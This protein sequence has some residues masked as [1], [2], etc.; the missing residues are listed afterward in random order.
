ME[1]VEH[2]LN[3]RDD[4]KYI[5]AIEYDYKNNIIYKIKHDPVAGKIIEQDLSFQ[6]FCWMRN[7]HDFVDIFYHYQSD[8]AHITRQEIK[9]R[10]EAA[11]KK[12][13]ITIEPLAD[14]GHPRLINGFKYIV[15]SSKGLNHLSEFFN[16]G[17]VNFHDKNN[18]LML[19][20]LEQYLLQKGKRLFKGMEDYN[21]VHRMTFDLETQDLTPEID[22]IYA[23]GVYDNRGYKKLLKAPTKDPT[24]QEEIDLIMDLFALID[25]IRPAVIITYNGAD[26]DWHF[27]QVRCD[28]LGIDFF[29]IVQ[30][31][32][33]VNKVTVKKSGVKIGSEIE[34]FQQY[35]LW[36]YHN[37]DTL[38][39]T[40]RAQAIDSDMKNTKLKYVCKYTKIA[41]KN[42]VY[43][44]GTHI[45][46]YWTD[47]D[48]YYFNDKDGRYLKHKPTILHQKFISRVDVQSN[49]DKIYLFGDNDE[50]R[51]EGGQAK[52]MRG[53]PNAIGIRTK[54]LPLYTPEAY[55]TDDELKENIKKINADINKVREA[56][57]LGK[58]V[59]LPEDGIGTGMANLKEKAPKTFAHVQGVI[60]YLEDYANGFVQVTGSYIVERYLEDDL[61]ETMEIDNVYNQTAFLLVKLIP[62]TFE[63]SVVMG[64]SV[65]WKLL[66]MEWSYYKGIAIPLRDI[67]RDFVGGLSR[68][69]MIGFIKWIIKL[70]YKSLYPSEQL[71][72]DI[73]PEVDVTG[74]M[75]SF[76]KYFHSQRFAAK[77]LE[78]KYK[79]SD[80]QLSAK[81]KRKQMPLKI[82]INSGFGSISSPEQLQ[83]AE[84]NVGEHITCN[85]RQFLRLVMRFFV[86]RGYTPL[87]NDTDGINFSRPESALSTVYIG[88]GLHPNVEL[89]K[90]YKGVNAH[91]AEFNDTYLYGE[92]ELALDGEWASELNASRKNYIV[93]DASGK[94]KLTGNSLKSRI[95]PTYIEEFFEKA[96]PVLM[97]GDGF[98]F[99]QMYNEHFNK[100]YNK[101]IPL[102]N[103]ANKAKVKC[104]IEEYQK[105][106]SDK[107]GRQLPK[108]AHMELLIANHIIPNIGDII[109]YVND[110][111]AVSHGDVTEKFKRNEKGK[112]IKDENGK[113]IPDG[114]YAYLVPTDTI[115]NNPELLGNY[116]VPKFIDAFNKKL[117]PLMVAFHPDVRSKILVD[118]P[119][120]RTLFT[121][122]ELELVCNMPDKPEDLDDLDEFFTPERGEHIFWER[123]NYNPDIWHFDDTKQNFKFYVPGYEK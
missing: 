119:E 10:V 34:D 78:S 12:H 71:V 92:M 43:I 88:K 11:K 77:D 1:E 108:Q 51:G 93:M 64:Q 47:P 72:F 42:R 123:Y 82:F 79:K 56:M 7:M 84:I 52:E 94:I 23:I 44:D 53:E 117:E 32:S 63:K 18:F 113:K 61:W 50:R 89:G 103:I 58:T 25:V 104:S 30:T 41:K 110:G 68:N 46:K 15:K 59:V 40:K 29:N 49:L 26:F 106:G 75:K 38:H 6:P 28:K 39:A 5:V 67:K 73:F 62:T 45:Y 16:Y 3:G 37:I 115:E 96:L 80:P 13:G 2:F 66:M 4:E 70:D 35:H 111:T 116:N 17:G 20:V 91:V 90:E 81:Y 97:K 95:M 122:S 9:S 48:P 100:I 86:D 14:Y 27:I 24:A 69:F 76:M 101:Q 83:W 74:V 109:Y 114:I 19:P 55:Y 65:G 33:P 120:D 87:M 105:R 98:G 36:G 54:K 22:K 107:N 112:L 85:A 21:D 60:K 121:N 8:P 102:V 118:K 99:V 57:L 31:L